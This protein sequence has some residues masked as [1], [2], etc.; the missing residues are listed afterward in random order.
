MTNDPETILDARMEYGHLLTALQSLGNMY[1][2]GYGAFFTINTLLA[3]A[4]GFSYSTMASSLGPKFLSLTHAVVPLTGM[5]MCGVAIYT[6]W[7]IANLQRR[8]VARGN[9]L[10]TI[11]SA[12]MFSQLGPH[13]G[14]YPISTTIGALMFLLLWAG[15]LF[16]A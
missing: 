4:L 16:V 10:E 15:A 14:G 12:R 9:E 6:A 5:F 7:F 3:T 1:W 13:S 11:L 2:V 8:A